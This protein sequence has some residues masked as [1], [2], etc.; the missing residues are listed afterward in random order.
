MRFDFVH[1]YRGS[2]SQGHL[3]KLRNVTPRGYRSWRG[4]PARRR[5]RDGMVS[6]AHI[7]EQHRLYLNSYSR[8]L[9]GPLSVMLTSPAGQRELPET[10]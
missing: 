10:G 6:L 7:R 8:R 5:Q 3:C 4:R 9:I 1:Q 2:L